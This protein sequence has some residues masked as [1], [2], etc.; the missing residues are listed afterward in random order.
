MNA[1]CNSDPDAIKPAATRTADYY[2]EALQ[3]VLE[4]IRIADEPVEGRPVIEDD[5]GR[6]RRRL[7]CEELDDLVTDIH[8]YIE[9]MLD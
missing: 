7:T 2:M 5:D 3:G 9:H 8:Q 1:T 6:P 4:L